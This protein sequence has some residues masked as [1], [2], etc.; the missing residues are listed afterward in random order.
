VVGI[1]NNRCKQNL[2][3]QLKVRGICGS[4]ML[5]SLPREFINYLNVVVSLE[6]AV[7]IEIRKDSCEEHH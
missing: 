2:C 7:T 1:C 6:K 3:V 5:D 4:E